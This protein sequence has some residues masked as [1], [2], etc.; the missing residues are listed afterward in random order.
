MGGSGRSKNIEKCT[1]LSWNFQR[2]EEVL[3]KSLLWGRYGY[4][5]ELHKFMSNDILLCSGKLCNGK[6][7]TKKSI[8]R[9]LHWV[10]LL[11]IIEMK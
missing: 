1:K 9:N 6:V 2:G 4:F 11:T 5:M 10:A 3:K 7:V 8:L